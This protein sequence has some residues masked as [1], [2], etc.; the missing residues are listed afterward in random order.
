MVS[1]PAGVT[2]AGF[3][4]DRPV[5]FCLATAPAGCRLENVQDGSAKVTC[6]NGSF[7]L[8]YSDATDENL[9]SELKSVMDRTVDATT[10]ISEQG[11]PAGGDGKF[12]AYQRADQKGLTNSV[13]IFKGKTHVW[14]CSAQVSD[15]Q[16]V[17]KEP[18]LKACRSLREL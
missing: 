10:Q 4:G 3:K 11:I 17:E 5:P 15:T 8:S 6:T 14:V 13:A 9:K 16:P 1:A 2:C 12:I 18:F 7:L